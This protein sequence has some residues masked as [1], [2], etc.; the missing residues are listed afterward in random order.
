MYRRVRIKY[1]IIN[2]L[3]EIKK[4]SYEEYHTLTGNTTFELPMGLM[5]IGAFYYV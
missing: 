1:I 2:F 3:H 5:S 4:V